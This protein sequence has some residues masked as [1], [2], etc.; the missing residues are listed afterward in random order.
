MSFLARVMKVVMKMTGG[1]VGHRRLPFIMSRFSFVVSLASLPSPSDIHISPRPT[2]LR[3]ESSHIQTQIQ[4]TPEERRAERKNGHPCPD[5][6]HL[7]IVV[8][9]E[10]GGMCSTRSTRPLLVSSGNK[11]GA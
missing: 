10:G 11:L 5:D 4:V 9:S 7:L 3:N 1:F 6:Y 8:L 2:Y